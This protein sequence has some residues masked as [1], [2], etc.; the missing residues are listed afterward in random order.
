ME[1][2]IQN[3]MPQRAH[4]WC[5]WHVKAIARFIVHQERV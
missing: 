2:A 5:K 1:V 3:V 4:R